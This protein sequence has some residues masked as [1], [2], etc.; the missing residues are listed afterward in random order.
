MK[1]L[2]YDLRKH[3]ETIQD[4]HTKYETITTTLYIFA[5]LQ[6]LGDTFKQQK[7]TSSQYGDLTFGYFN[8]TFKI[9]ASAFSFLV[10]R[11][12]LNI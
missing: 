2:E 5:L 9:D 1:M 6:N 11:R 4:W 12:R 7:M 10:E 8:S 3:C